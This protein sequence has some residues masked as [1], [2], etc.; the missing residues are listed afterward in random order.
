MSNEQFER[1]NRNN[2]N[3]KGKMEMVQGKVQGES[4]DF[5]EDGRLKLRGYY[6]DDLKHGKFTTYY[7]SGELMKKAG[8][9]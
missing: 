1:G 9:R 7:N 6:K 5:Y 2:G 3:I 8:F 4:K